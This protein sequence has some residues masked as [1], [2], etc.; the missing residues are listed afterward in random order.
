MHELASSHWAVAPDIASA[1]VREKG[2]PWRIAHQSVGTMVR[3]AHE[4]GLGPKDVTP[5]LLD[6]AAI[7]YHGEPIGLRG[8]TFQAALDPTNA[9]NARKLYGGPAPEQTSARAADSWQR[10]EA[11]QNKV[12]EMEHRLS[13]A[14]ARL[15]AGIDSMLAQQSAQTATDA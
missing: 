12:D 2:L 10:V 11:D 6:E 3:L 9:V 1:A 4:R 15:E 8:D 5:E 14:E 13:E 7:E